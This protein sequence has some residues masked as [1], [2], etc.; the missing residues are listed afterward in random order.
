MAEGFLL[1]LSMNFGCMATCLPVMLP[2]ILSGEQTAVYSVLRF[3]AG[4]LI[5][6]LL[7]A[8]SFGYAGLYFY[9][10]VNPDIFAL[11]TIPLALWQIE[12]LTTE[13]S[14]PLSLPPAMRI[15]GW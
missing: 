11:L 10:K 7:F 12:S 2:F 4:R 8:S 9:G 6:Y 13:K 1:G 5:A 3:M 14:S 15:T